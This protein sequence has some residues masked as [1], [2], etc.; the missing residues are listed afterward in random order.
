MAQLVLNIRELSI[1]K[2]TPFY[3]NFGKDPNVFG[4][5]L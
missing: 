4:T 5:P 1:T 3:A 2:E